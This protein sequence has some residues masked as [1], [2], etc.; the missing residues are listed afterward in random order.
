MLVTWREECE[1]QKMKEDDMVKLLLEA[2]KDVE[3]LDLVLEVQMYAGK[4]CIQG[5]HTDW[6]TLKW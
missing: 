3:R 5:S 4:V 6:K 1:R 2:L